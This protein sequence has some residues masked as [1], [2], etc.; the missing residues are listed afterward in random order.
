L[1][2]GSKPEDVLRDFA[3]RQCDVLRVWA[4][5]FSTQVKEQLGLKYPS[6]DLSRAAEA[7]NHR[8]AEARP[9]RQSIKSGEAQKRTGAVKI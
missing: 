6:H 7:I 1:A 5:D 9:P 8:F 2:K 4:G 3:N